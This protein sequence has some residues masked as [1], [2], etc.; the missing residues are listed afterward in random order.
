MEVIMKKSDMIFIGIGVLA[1]LIFFSIIF[2]HGENQKIDDFIKET[3]EFILM[4][5]IRTQEPDEHKDFIFDYMGTGLNG[6]ELE[7]IGH[8]VG[9]EEAYNEEDPY[10][11]M[12]Y[13]ASACVNRALNWY[14]GDVE[15]MICDNNGYYYQMNPEY[16]W[17]TECNGFNF[18]QNYSYIMEIVYAAVEHPAPVYY[19]SVDDIH[20]D[21]ATPYDII[22]GNWFYTE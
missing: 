10:K 13:V 2:V 18:N 17:R 12:F 19:W 14:D 20:S 22:G 9:F 4:Q 6:R 16:I 15:A 21:Y 5:D 3:D 8:V 11:A 7:L 1:I